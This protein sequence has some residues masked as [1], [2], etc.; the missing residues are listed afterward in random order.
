MTD[1]M[2]QFM[3]AR[4]QGAAGVAGIVG[5]APKWTLARKQRVPDAPMTGIA[6]GMTP[7]QELSNDRLT[8]AARKHFPERRGDELAYRRGTRF[9]SEPQ[10]QIR[11]HTKRV[12]PNVLAGDPNF[13]FRRP[14]AH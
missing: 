1:S 11:S 9:V 13:P 3:A 8:G 2:D 7:L 12:L 5:S 14:G 10:E 6:P 4:N